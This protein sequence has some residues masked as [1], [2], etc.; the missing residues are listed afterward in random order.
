MNQADQVARMGMQNEKLTNNTKW[1]IDEIRRTGIT[2]H[3]KII[4]EI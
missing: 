3:E 1:D 4:R 2:V